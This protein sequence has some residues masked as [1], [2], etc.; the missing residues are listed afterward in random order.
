MLGTL[1]AVAGLGAAMI[2]PLPSLAADSARALASANGKK[3][4]VND[5]AAAT[6]E[7]FCLEWMKRLA[8]RD[9]DNRKGIKWE[10]GSEGVRGAYVGYDPDHVC[11]MSGDGRSTPTGKITYREVRYEKRGATIPEAAAS[12]PKPI[13]IFEVTEIFT[14]RNGHWDF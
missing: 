5:R 7:T 11:T 1:I 10:E 8:V 14:F 13:E 12:K 2:L 9:A 6:F 3:P 4:T